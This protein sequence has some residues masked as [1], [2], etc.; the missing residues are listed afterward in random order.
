MAAAPV[1]GAPMPKVYSEGVRAEAKALL[2]ALD[3]ERAAGM[4]WPRLAKRLAAEQ[5]LREA[6]VPCGADFWTERFGWMS[7]SETVVCRDCAAVQ[8]A[9]S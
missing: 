8:E 4:G 1:E 9:A 2:A 3:E 5:T 7:C 6:L